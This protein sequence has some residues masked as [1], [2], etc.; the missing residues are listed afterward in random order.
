MRPKVAHD[1]QAKI[2]RGAL[3][4]NR[5]S[6]TVSRS[7][8]KAYRLNLRQPPRRIEDFFLGLET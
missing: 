1:A 4:Q 2:F 5:I 3:G 7:A 8:H 6:S